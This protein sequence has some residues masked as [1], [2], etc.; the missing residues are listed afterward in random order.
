MNID[1]VKKIAVIGAGNMGH[2]I[3]TLCALRGFTTTCTDIDAVTLKKAETFVSS[4]LQGRVQKGR[5]T[6]DQA[7]QVQA[8]VYFTSNLEEAV[9]DTDYIIEAAIEVLDVKRKIFED[10]DRMAPSHTILATNSSQNRKL[11]DSGRDQAAFQGV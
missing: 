11:A 2:Q 9:K 6:E 10:L 3:A 1:E 7:K 8:N 5:L 4:Y